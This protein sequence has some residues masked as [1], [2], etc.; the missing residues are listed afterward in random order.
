MEMA[1][2]IA[3]TPRPATSTESAVLNPAPVTGADTK[4]RTTAV[5]NIG[6]IASAC[7][8]AWM[9]PSRRSPSSPPAAGGGA[10]CDMTPSSGRNNL[11]TFAPRPDGCQDRGLT[12]HA[13]GV[14]Y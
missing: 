10:A 5:E 11:D 9:V 3:S 12:P 7:A 6:P 2:A 4:P 1:Y 14:M 8:T 13:G